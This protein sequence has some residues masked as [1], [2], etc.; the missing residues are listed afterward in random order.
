MFGKK[1]KGLTKK[2]SRRTK[3]VYETQNFRA[4]KYI[5]IFNIIVIFVIH[6]LLIIKIMTPIYDNVLSNLITFAMPY[7]FLSMVTSIFILFIYSLYD[8]NE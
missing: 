6:T 4:F 3:Y 2:G 1:C 5:G 8:E 7:L